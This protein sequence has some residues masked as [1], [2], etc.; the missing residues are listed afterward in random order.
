MGALKADDAVGGAAAR[1]VRRPAGGP[2][3]LRKRRARAAARVAR[4]RRLSGAALRMALRGRGDHR[5]PPR[6]H[7]HPGLFRA[8]PVGILAAG[9]GGRA[10]RARLLGQR[11]RRDRRPDPR[12]LPQ[13]AQGDGDARHRQRDHQHAVAHDHHARQHA[14]DGHVDL[15][16]RRRDAA[17]L[18][19]RAGHRHLL[20]HLFVGAGDGAR[21]SCGWACRART[22]SS[23]KRRPARPAKRSCRSRVAADAA[24]ARSFERPPYADDALLLA[25]RARPDARRASRVSTAPGS[26]RCCSRSSSRRPGSSSSRSCPATRSCSS[27]APSW[28]PRGS[29]CTCSSYCWWSPRFSAIRSTTRSDT[30]SA[31]RSSS[32][33]IRAGS[34]RNTCAGRRRSTTS[35]AASRSSSGASCR[36]SAR[37]RRSWPASRACPTA[38]SCAFNVVGAVLWIA[39]LVYAGYLFG[40]IPWVKENLTFIVIGIV[41][42]SLIPAVT[43][44]VQERRPAR[45]DAGSD[46]LR[47]LR[48]QADVRR[49]RSAPAA[50]PSRRRATRGRR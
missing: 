5:Q 35:T 26:T 16:L 44:F 12:E 29:T 1:R 19:A 43:T 32:G 15:L 46:A 27:P 48:G 20:R 22:W 25:V 8:V 36:S 6:R 41:V 2:R 37:S 28:R 31:R 39:S 10:R 40:N 9:A 14:D 33:R 42:V 21:S 30:T 18:R 24:L 34:G 13:D 23:R 17:P 50:A 49:R 7:H 38:A 45:I 3:A 11:V 47:E 4:H